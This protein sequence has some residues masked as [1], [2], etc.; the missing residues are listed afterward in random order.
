MKG[1]LCSW[2]DMR[3]I[4]YVLENADRL[5]G[6]LSALMVCSRRTTRYDWD[7]TIEVMDACRLW[8]RKWRK[9]EGHEKPIE[10]IDWFLVH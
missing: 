9:V 3:R 5:K 10:A 2:R 1:K 4:K 7:K 8:G 6:E